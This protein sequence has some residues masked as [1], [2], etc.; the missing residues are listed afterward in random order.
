MMPTRHDEVNLVEEL[1]GKIKAGEVQ[2]WKAESVLVEE[3]NVSAPE[4]FQI[5]ALSRRKCIEE[6]TG[7]KFNYLELPEQPYLMQWRCPKDNS[8]WH[9]EARDTDTA[10][11]HCGS[12]LE[13]LEPNPIDFCPWSTIISVVRKNTTH[14][15]V[16]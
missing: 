10:C 9:L 11:T 15:Q 2:P 1:A 8:I 16:K 5:A 6:L 13:P 4:H 12:E 7:F 3:Y 14:L